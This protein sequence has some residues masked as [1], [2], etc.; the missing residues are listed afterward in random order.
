MHYFIGADLGTSAL[1]LL[2]VDRDGQIIKT[3][4][5]P[6]TGLG[7]ASTCRLV[8]CLYFGHAGADG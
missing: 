1:K 7:R 2:L 5:L 3:V 8:G 6:C 4:T